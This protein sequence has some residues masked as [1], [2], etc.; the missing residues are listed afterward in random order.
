MFGGKSNTV[1]GTFLLTAIHIDCNQ[2]LFFTDQ[3]TAHIHPPGTTK[4]VRV[5][6]L[7]IDILYRCLAINT[8]ATNLQIAGKYLLYRAPFFAWRRARISI[9]GG[10][11]DDL[12]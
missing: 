5:I 3:S 12:K 4:S 8:Y 1:N 9:L 10:W 7:F 6:N 11:R 2:L